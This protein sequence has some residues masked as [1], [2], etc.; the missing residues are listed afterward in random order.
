MDD[1]AADAAW[2][3]PYFSICIWSSIWLAMP[4]KFALPKR[5]YT[6]KNG[7]W[8]DGEGIWRGRDKNGEYY[9]I[10]P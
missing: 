2:M 1:W 3:T 7:L 8:W 4:P 10:S 6:R 9:H 5:G